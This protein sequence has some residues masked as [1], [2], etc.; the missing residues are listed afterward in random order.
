MLDPSYIERLYLTGAQT[1]VVGGGVSANTHIR[2]VF[3]ENMRNEYPQVVLR[4]PSA[5]LTTDNAV[6]I[7]LAGFYRALRREFAADIAAS[8]NLSLSS[9]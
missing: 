3:A 6:M 7:A 4:I 2:R 8:G 5:A 1:L 9:K